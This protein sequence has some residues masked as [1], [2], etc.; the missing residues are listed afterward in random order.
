MR[1]F[2]RLPLR[3]KLVVLSVAGALTTGAATSLAAY[4]QVRDT[5]FAAAEA[6]LEAAAKLHS[7]HLGD[8][9][10][11]LR[12]DAQALAAMPPVAGIM[13]SSA[14]ADG[15]DPL[16]SSTL[17]LWQGRL[18]QIF[19]SF[20]RSRP[21]YTQIRFIGIAD[22]WR[23]IVRVDRGPDGPRAVPET[24]LQQKG[25]EPYLGNLAA[26][27]RGEVL[28]SQVTYNREHGRPV[29]PPTLRLVQPV[30]GPAGLYGA[31]VINTD[32][33]DLLRAARFDPQPGSEVQVLTDR[34]DH[35]TFRPGA[36]AR[37]SFHED[38]DW[39]P[40]PF[41]AALSGAGDAALAR[42]GGQV[43]RATPIVAA[44]DAAPFTLTLVT[45]TTAETLYASARA[46]LLRSSAISA[47]LV[48]LA[49]AVAA[50]VGARLPLGR[51]A[52]ALRD[53]S[54]DSGPFEVPAGVDDDTLSIALTF[55]E[56]SSQVLRQTFRIRSIYAGVPDA[57][58]T[59]G[60][61]GTIEDA[62]PAVEALFGYTPEELV[63]G[64][65]EV[66]MPEDIA[67]QHA[68]FVEAVSDMR[69]G[70]PMTTGRDIHGRRK[71]GSLVPLDIS[72]SGAEYDGTMHFIGVMRDITA[73]K[74]AE[75]EM[76]ALLA[77]LERSNEELDKFA[78]VASHD[79]KA[80]LRVIDNA[81]GWLE[82]DLADVLTEDT[83]ESLDMLRG[84]VRRMERLL[85]DLLAHSRIGRDG[86]EEAV[87]GGAE[88]ADTLQGLLNLPQG[89][90]L[91]VS[92]AFHRI[93]V[94][95][96]PLTTILLNL[97]SN[98][99]K[100][101]DRRDGNIWLDVAERDRA[102]EFT[103]ADDGP[104]I[105]P[106][107]HDRIFEMFQTLRPRD[108]VDGSGLGLAMVRKYAA[109]AGGE[110]SV[111]SDGSRGTRFTLLWPHT[112]ASGDRGMAA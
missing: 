36:P 18:E 71:D 102:Y 34:G 46:A 55:A 37:L 104:G 47:L 27:A 3:R 15:V 65:L 95:T 13:R 35:M 101:H 60:K 107:Y 106:E 85:D 10:A 74:Q 17:A 96:M 22:N 111:A 6:R 98:A 45:A 7:D 20:L 91:H 52:A 77:A 16:D 63:G 75:A 24:A 67:P 84:R 62:N 5:E 89:M 76:A 79:L 92:D 38:A 59:I 110:I 21:H 23:E 69:A 90:R 83:R 70:R 103:V 112:P 88:L 57:I 51:L 109:I 56:M 11:L 4:V 82:E 97:L 2:R 14:T 80:P 68:R 73:R 49:G 105:A 66:L 81:A 100:H 12:T 40:S 54:P 41:A 43:F 30:T 93:E 94:P 78:Y 86:G 28:F 42:S 19:D 108:E 39:A 87:V 58:V 29:G 9:L 8:A 25:E 33:A 99:V 32:F 64:P 48:T 31:I 61:D 53:H 26:L 72:I 50:L 44:R 1:G